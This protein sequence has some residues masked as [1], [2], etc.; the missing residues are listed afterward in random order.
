LKPVYDWFDE[1]LTTADLIAARQ[2]LDDL[3]A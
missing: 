3:T 2:L 1:G